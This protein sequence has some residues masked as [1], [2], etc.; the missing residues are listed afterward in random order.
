[1]GLVFFGMFVCKTNSQENW[2]KSGKARFIY[3]KIERKASGKRMEFWKRKCGMIK[4]ICN[5]FDPAE[6]HSGENW[7][8]FGKAEAGDILEVASM[9]F[10]LLREK[11]KK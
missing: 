11:Q 8:E 4:P 7:G 6:N 2:K 3:T 9:P 5:Q 1:M 10:E